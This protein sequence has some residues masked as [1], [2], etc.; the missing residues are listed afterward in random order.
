MKSAITA[1]L[2][3]KLSVN[4]FTVLVAVQAKTGVNSTI[5]TSATSISDSLRGDLSRHAVARA[6]RNL[7]RDNWIVW[8]TKGNNRTSTIFV[9]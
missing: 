3:G 1:F 6:L 9:N 4:E 8:N 5:T 7:Q 2:D